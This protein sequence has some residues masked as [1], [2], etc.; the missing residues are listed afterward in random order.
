MEKIIFEDDA[1]SF[2]REQAAQKGYASAEKYLLDLVK[3]DAE[4]IRPNQA[5]R[6]SFKQAFK[7]A[8]QGKVLSKEELAHRM[9]EDES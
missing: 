1:A 7:E 8:L 3:A 4:S 9:A 6:D 5:I 2:I